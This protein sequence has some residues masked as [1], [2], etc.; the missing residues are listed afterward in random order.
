MGSFNLVTE[1]SLK[2]SRSFF[3]FIDCLQKPVK[4]GEDVEETQEKQ[5]KLLE[6]LLPVIHDIQDAIYK[7]QCILLKS[8]VEKMKSIEN[9][10]DLPE[11]GNFERA[12][13]FH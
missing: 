6:S 7:S 4:D 1:E 8:C 10:Q 9:G 2:A 3:L 13:K 12:S 11:H 5:L